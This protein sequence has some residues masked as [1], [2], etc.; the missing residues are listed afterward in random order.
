MKEKLNFYNLFYIFIFCSLFGYVIEFFWTFLKKGVLINHS[1][2]AIGTFNFVYGISAVVFTILLYKYN[3][4]KNWKI[5][6]FSFVLGTIL[7]YL[8]SYFMELFIG[9]SAWDYS[10]K[11]MNINGRVALL[12]SILWGFLGV[13]WIKYLYPLIMKLIDKINKKV[14]KILIPFIIVFLILDMI[15]TYSAILRARKWEQGI[16][17]QNSYEKFLDHTF[18]R[19]FLKNMFNNQWK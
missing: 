4:E 16:P 1:A 11:F 14:G 17:P 6:L 15:F 18:N 13:F 9:F 10:K 7:E 19:D 2:V 12:Y 3:N 8:M 5:F